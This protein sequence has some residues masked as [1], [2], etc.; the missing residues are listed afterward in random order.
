MALEFIETSIQGLFIIKP[1]IFGDDRGYFFESYV[2]KE[3]EK[4]GIN[5]NF[6]QDNESYSKK[7]VL[8]GLHFQTK[9][10]QGK[11]VRVI[12]GEVLDVAVDLRYNSPTFGKW[13]SVILS[14]ENKFQFYLPEGFA[15]GFLV[16]SDDAIFTYKCTNY[17]KPEY[18]SGIRW[19]DPDL[20]IDWPKD[21]LDDFIISQKDESQQSFSEFLKKKPVF[22]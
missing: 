13:E 11:L 15:H 7:G 19:N 21:G 4:I 1:K 5:T 16:L 6:V 3:F 14:G 9:F 8:R 12:K 20:N 17:Y 2:E 10:T 22:V 18:D